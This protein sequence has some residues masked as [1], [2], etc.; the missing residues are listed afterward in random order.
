MRSLRRAGVRARVRA[1]RGDYAPSRLA[2]KLERM[3]MDPRWR[4][5]VKV[6]LPSLALAG[7][8]GLTLGDHARASAL[9]DWAVG[10]KRALEDR[11]EF[12]VTALGLRGA[13]PELS[14]QIVALADPLLPDSSLRLDLPALR[15]AVLALPRVAGASVAV[16]D[17]GILSIAVTEHPEAVLHRAADGLHVLRGDGTRLMDVASRL[18]RPNLPVIAGPHAD[19]AVGEALG[20]LGAAGPLR[21]RI[22]GLVRIGGRR[23]DA[24]LESGQRI[25][26]PETGAADA[27]RLAAELDAVGDVTA[28]SVTHVDLRRPARPVLRLT[29]A[30]SEALHAARAAAFRE[31]SDG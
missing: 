5:L 9:V 26:L 23:W 17:G 6:G 19:E 13:G 7:A 24:V 27:I 12:A 2:W 16:D 29:D 28:R 10:V 25:L 11:P 14:A 31:T 1:R 20:V 30:A 4:R 15:Q 8:V 21:A 18:A 3:W 22:V